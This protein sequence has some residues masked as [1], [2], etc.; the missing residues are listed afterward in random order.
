VGVDLTHTQE[1]Y[2]RVLESYVQPGC[3]WLEVGCGRQI[4]PDWAMRVARQREL[5]ERAKMLVGMD[6]DDAL[7]AHPLLTH[8]VIGLGNAMPFRPGS[9][10]LVSANMVVEHVHRPEEF[11]REVE[12]ILD[13]GGRF[14]F[15][16]TNF[17]NYM[18]F[19]AHFVPA[20]IKNRIVWKLEHRRPEDIFP[21]RY[22]MNTEAAIRKAVSHTS[23]R[24]ER[25]SV[26]GS[27]G[28]FGG[29]GPVGWAE[30]LLTKAISLPSGHYNSNLICVLRR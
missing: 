3:R 13:V 1:H 7:Y 26:N 22:E 30:V 18:I 8:R 24:V 17:H 5:T 27:V 23:F 10:D 12:R 16:T 19:L 9:F 28:V 14:V 11:L 6:V 21:T 20:V 15:H 2:A 29:L 4:L 25:L